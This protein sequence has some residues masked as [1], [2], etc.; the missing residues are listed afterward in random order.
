MKMELRIEGKTIVIEAEGVV[1][2]KIIEDIEEKEV[3]KPLT[4][5][6]KEVSGDLYSRLVELRREL[7]VSA[8]VPP[9]VVFKDLTLREMAEKLPQDLTELGKIKGVGAAKLDKYGAAFLAV[10]NEGVAA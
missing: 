2:V 6:E 1:S 9:Y 3:E 10:I 8:N 7:A 4:V 5:R